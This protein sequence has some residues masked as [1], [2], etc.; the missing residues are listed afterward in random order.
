MDEDKR[1]EALLEQ[2]L[3]S[4]GTPEE[5]C[6][7]CPELL[8]AVR[9]GWEEVRTLRAEVGALFPQ[10]T[11]DFDPS[12]L[13]TCPQPTTH[14]PRIC[15]YEVQKVL[16]Y[17]GM[18]VV[19]KA[20]HLRLNR[21]VALKMLLA[22]P[23]ARPEQLERFQREAQA[24][25]RLRH[26]NIVQIYE[27][28]D[29]DGR[30][31]FAMEF[32]EGGSLVDRFHNVPQPAHQVAALVATLA[33]AVH[34]AHQSG[35][36][37][38]DLK[39]AN[40]L[41]TADGTPKVTD[42]G[43][44][45]RLEDNGGLTLSGAVLG[46]PS[47]M[48]PEQA[49][50][51]K[52]AIGPATDVYALGAILYEGLTG[53][54]PF[55]GET[56]TATLQQV[57][58]DEPVPPGRLNPQVPR[59][60]TTICLKCLSKE[61]QRRYFSAA[62]LA[63]D[64]GR[65]LRNEPIRAR[66]V[67]IP[68]RL[69]RWARRHPGPAALTGALVAT[70][71]VA[72]AIILWQW[73]VAENARGDAD[74]MATRLVFD[75]GL[76]LCE[77]GD[78]GPGLLWLAQAL[79]QAERSGDTALM[80]ALRTNLTA[81]SERLVAPRVS[82]AFGASVSAVA[83]HP[84]GKRLLVAR[85]HDPFGKPGPGEARMVDPDTWKELSPPMQHP[86]GVRAAAFSPDGT[87]I[88]TSGVE[89]TVRLWDTKSGRPLA[90]PLPFGAIVSALAFAPNGETFATATSA[91]ATTGEA[92]I[93]DAVTGQP[94]TPVMPHRG[95]VYCLAF[96]PDGKTLMT[97]CA[98]AKTAG[99]PEGG[100]A[101]FWDSRTGLPVGPV[102]VHVAP[103]RTVAFS[104]DGQTVVT[105]S[106][107]GL[108]SRWRRATWETI[109]PPLHHLAAVRAVVFSPDGRSLLTGDGIHDRPN[110]G[111]GVLRLWD[112][113]SGHLVTNP[114]IHPDDVQSISHHPDGRSFAT[115]CSDG[116]ARVFRLGAFQP[117]R[118]RYLDGI[119]AP[120]R[121][122][123]SADGSV[124]ATFSTDGRRLLAGGETPY[125]Q[126]A[127]RLVDVLTERAR[128]LLPDQKSLLAN[129][130]CAVGL[131][132]SLS[133]GG[134]LSTLGSLS[135]LRNRRSLIEGVAFDPEGKIAV[136]TG[137]DGRMRIWDAESAGLVQGPRSYGEKTIPWM[138]LMPD[139]H[140]LVTGARGRPIEVWDRDT[141]K[142]VAGPIIGDTCVQA[143]TLSPDGRTLATAG[144]GG[145]IQLWDV[146]TGQLRT[147]FDAVTQTIWALRFSPDGRTLL[148]GGGGTA[149]LFDVGTGKQRCQ[150]LPHPATVWE[151]RFS[152]DGNRLLTVC[153]DEYRDLHAGMA[154]LWDAR[155][156]KPLAPPLRHRVAGLAA[157]FDPEG[158]LVATG[159][160]D[161]DVRFWDA[162]TGTPVGP[163]LVQSGP[164]PA[165][166][167]VAGT[168]FLA[169][170]G[171]DGNLALW[172]VPE[173]REGSATEVRRWVQSITGQEN[174]E[175]D[176]VR[177][178]K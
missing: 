46:T 175:T 61:P 74:R 18:G 36:V 64:L 75:R 88:L 152:P 165:I 151:A 28:G 26:P 101:R 31:Y 119:Q 168:R 110:E 65:F 153:S 112:F 33:E 41:L 93:W 4:G 79:E 32:I 141:G 121:Y 13:E 22:G 3:D 68:G 91:S 176:A 9:A 14:L 51:D 149:W 62:D 87:R 142:R 173:A 47:Y 53:R 150:P 111:E 40:I 8:P 157:A 125:G 170:A 137:E 117:R 97:G 158:R 109:S 29:A 129:A 23:C 174:D 171:R 167:F 177:D 78:I 102:L 16:G 163:A 106:A 113:D 25:A 69:F 86:R 59:D 95:I 57:V 85:W 5:I 133:G 128:D 20:W 19:Y 38:R 80:P 58:A 118:R 10:T 92:R 135:S 84:D 94:V 43:L 114:W 73:R 24:I 54:P 27:V 124:V 21:P 100:D 122:S 116:H 105:G 108:V 70:A 96:S 130:V 90:K 66:P 48:A 52:Q 144:D 160:F 76:A 42:F 104:P 50:G 148:A 107:D 82:P 140:T 120:Q 35:I 45:R 162:S 2:L 127:A 99:H 103:V 126:Q 146:R 1:V 67:G 164:I 55:H 7:D 60:L 30:P 71:L 39:P 159:G 123:D 154:Q 169:A 81:W 166:A 139:E 56:S 143:M 83:Y 138:M 37:H 155:S 63:A 131:S 136:T 161:G 98:V 132:A 34:A 145:I 72:F 77:R 115:G 134:G 15:G 12:G 11:P 17:G 156:G 44:A 178:L 172:P 6:R 49:R 147:R 89:G